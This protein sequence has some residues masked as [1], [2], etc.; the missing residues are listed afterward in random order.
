MNLLDPPALVQTLDDLATLATAINSEHSAVTKALTAG[1]QHARAAGELLIQAK[2][3]CAPRRLAAVARKALPRD[4]A[5]AG[6]EVHAPGP[7]VPGNTNC[8]SH[9]TIDEA[10]NA[11]RLRRPVES[12]G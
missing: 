7:A 2:Q 11:V 1:V 8:N 6:A 5:A 12:E 3:K 10:V 4:R 9:L